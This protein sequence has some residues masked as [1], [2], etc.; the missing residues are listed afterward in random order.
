MK[1]IRKN[2][3]GLI[4]PYRTAV[5]FLLLLSGRAALAVI[6]VTSAFVLNVGA[7]V[8]ITR[9]SDIQNHGAG[10]PLGSDIYVGPASGA[11]DTAMLQVQ[12]NR[13]AS[14]GGGR[15]FLG[16]YKYRILLRD[17]YV[18]YRVVLSGRW[19]PGVQ[20]RAGNDFTNEKFS[21]Y[22]TSNRT[23]KIAGALENVFVLRDDLGAP[24]TTRGLLDQ[25]AQFSGV[26]ITIAG[27]D[28]AARNV[29]VGGFAQCWVSVGWQRPRLDN[30]ICDGQS[31][32]VVD[33]AH[34]TPKLRGF[35]AWPF[36]TANL[37]GASTIRSVIRGVSEDGVGGRRL[38]VSTTNLRSGDTV[39]ITGANGALG[40]NGR[41]TA[42]VINGEYLDLVG[43]ETIPKRRAQMVSGSPF[44]LVDKI[45]GLAVGQTVRGSG[46]PADAKIVALWPGSSAISLSERANVSGS[47]V[48]LSITDNA[49]SGGGVLMVDPNQRSGPGLTITRS[50]TSECSNCFIYGHKIGAILGDGAGWTQLM[51]FSVDQMVDLHDPTTVALSIEGS[52][53]G[54]SWIGGTSNSTGR[55]LS[56]NSS[57][58]VPHLISGV[59]LNTGGGLLAELIRG[60]LTIAG[61]GSAMPLAVGVGA[62][63]SGLIFTGNAMPSAMA[64]YASDSARA[65]TLIAPTNDAPNLEVGTA[66]VRTGALLLG[67]AS[68][69]PQFPLTIRSSYLSDLDQGA[70]ILLE[71][72]AVD[73]K[74]YLRV[75]SQGALQVLGSI[76]NV[77]FNLAENGSATF[78]GNLLV[79]T[80]KGYGRA[81]ALRCGTD[82]KTMETSNDLHG[83]IIT[84]SGR[85]TSCRIEWAH[86]R[87]D[88]PDCI[89]ASPDMAALTS[90]LATSTGLE[91]SNT[92]GIPERRAFTYN[93]F[94]R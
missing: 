26:G 90:Y 76:Y 92:A 75:S 15:V 3:S 46:I 54:T 1:Y 65:V 36:L 17:L 33:R 16:P 55:V 58:N 79:P 31:G 45:D 34:D 93:C 19:Y 62:N 47:D 21:L 66:V 29:V 89:V 18:P 49:Y 8:S 40:V 82:A 13:A 83:T 35:H 85:Y 24:T 51:N 10:W 78:K 42:K 72:P 41:W 73:A 77:L 20:G 94:G 14:A 22:V 87:P 81:P 61:N 5:D 43:S 4:G 59:T 37:P 63:A 56:I 86:Q 80:I 67:A 69:G 11:D 53:W 71:H 39:W 30:M 48:A 7:E 84:G 44:I 32:I 60:R 64:H 57:S 2:A 74:K 23:I 9:P 38:N 91:L 88:P 70:Q 50:E 28:G 68:A 6:W 52:A 25:V 12:L 27:H